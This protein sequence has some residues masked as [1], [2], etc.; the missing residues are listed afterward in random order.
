LEWLVFVA[1]APPNVERSDR[2]NKYDCENQKQTNPESY[3][4]SGKYEKQKRRTDANYARDN[5]NGFKGHG[6]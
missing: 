5:E 2:D 3:Q 4:S 6:N 1:T